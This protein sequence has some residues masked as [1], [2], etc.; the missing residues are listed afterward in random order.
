M[1]LF[2]KSRK[3]TLFRIGAGQK[4]PSTSFSPVT[5]TNVGIIPQNFLIFGFNPFTTLVKN[6]KFEPSASHKLLN[7]NQ[8]HPPNP[9][10]I[11]V[12]ITSLIEMLQ[13]P[14]FG[15]MNTSTI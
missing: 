1:L 15:Y 3:F 10:K 4:G 12:A 9:Y 14:N 11:E 7:L 6:F 2:K 13:S 5:S 8:D